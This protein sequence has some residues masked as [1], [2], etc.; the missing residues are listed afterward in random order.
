MRV[1]ESEGFKVT[2]LPVG[3]NG[4]INLKV[5]F[6]FSRVRDLTIRV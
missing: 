4:L 2:Y 3:T 1:L 6:T 5:T